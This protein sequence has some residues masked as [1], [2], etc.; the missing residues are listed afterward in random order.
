MAI[1]PKSSGIDSFRWKL[2]IAEVHAKV[3]NVAVGDIPRLTARLVID[4]LYVLIFS[5][6]LK[7]RSGGVYTGV[8]AKVGKDAPG[9]RFLQQA[10]LAV[11]R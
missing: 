5:E 3:E 10:T 4:S 7:F 9:G 11:Y 6:L 8:D 1:V 2:P